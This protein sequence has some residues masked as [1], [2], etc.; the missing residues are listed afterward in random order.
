L[1]L[2]GLTQGVFRYC[3]LRQRG[4][5]AALERLVQLQ[6]PALGRLARSDVDEGR[7]R[8]ARLAVLV[9]QRLRIADEMD[10]GSAVVEDDLF[11]EF[12]YGLSARGAL[13]R[14][15]VRRELP[16]A[17]VQHAEAMRRLALW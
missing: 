13:D 5:N 10:R 4:F 17:G 7:D 8:A 12:P 14:E 1:Q 16:A 2:L 9:Q 11:L 3:T 15:L 6:Q